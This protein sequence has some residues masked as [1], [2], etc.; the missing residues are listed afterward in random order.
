MPGGERPQRLKPESFCAANGTTEVVPFPFFAWTPLL[1]WPLFLT[2][3]RF[4]C[5]PD[6]SRHD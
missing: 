6:S 3:F 5:H 1:A 4:S 2:S